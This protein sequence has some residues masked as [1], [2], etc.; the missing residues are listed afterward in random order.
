MY[1]ASMYLY[2]ICLWY[3]QK[4]EEDIGYPGTGVVMVVS[5]CVSA[6]NQAWVLCRSNSNC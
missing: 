2:H 5:H 4:P 3:P 6:G 1:F